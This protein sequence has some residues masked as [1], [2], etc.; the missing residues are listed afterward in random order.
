M[1]APLTALAAATAVLLLTASPSAA[2]DPYRW[3]AYYGPDDAGVNCYF[4]TLQQCQAAISGNG[5]FCSE[6]LW[7]TGDGAQPAV[8]RK[9]QRAPR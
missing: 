3:C 8:R 2:A 9:A 7:Y 4:V 1:R 5:G 6:N